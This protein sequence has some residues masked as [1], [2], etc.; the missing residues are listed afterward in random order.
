MEMAAGPERRIDKLGERDGREGNRARGARRPVERRRRGPVAGD[1]R[2]GPHDD[3]VAPHAGGIEDQVFPIDRD[4]CI[5][6]HHPALRP[7]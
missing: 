4:Q 5:G 3:A 7:G 2:R 1:L 6:H